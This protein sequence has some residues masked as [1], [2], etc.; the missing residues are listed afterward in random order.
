MDYQELLFEIDDPV[1]TVTLNRPDKL[2]AITPRTMLELGHALAEAE[3]SEAVVGIVITGA[4]RGFC[5]GLDM[6][7]L[8][9]IHKAGSTDTATEMPD[10]GAARPGDPGMGPDF[11]RGGTSLLSL[12]KP[13]IAAIN[14]PCA[15][16]GFSLAMLCDMRFMSDAAAMSTA[17]SNLGLVA[18]HGMSWLLPR[19]IGTS[20]A[21]DVLWTGR[22]IAGNEALSLGLVNRV[23]EPD[24]LLE[25]AQGYIRGLASTVSPNSLMFMKRQVYT[26]LMQPLGQAMEETEALQ[27][28][29][30][31]WPD[32][33]EGIAAFR[34]RRPPKFP[35]VTGD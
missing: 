2:N 31:T 24:R 27:D 26:H 14:G 30:M 8:G 3:H 19:L 25:E 21:L 32:L 17:F 23:V 6:E 35:R 20:R 15:G 10:L 22:K 5:A 4:G 7:V 18:E 28:Q 12:R 9:K 34:K 13:V 33:Q 16:F 1:A 29:S 11:E